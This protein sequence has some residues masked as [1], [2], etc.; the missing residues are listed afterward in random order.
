MIATVITV[1]LA[2]VSISACSS[3]SASNVTNESVAV[4][5]RD[6]NLISDPA[7]RGTSWRLWIPGDGATSV[8]GDP[9]PNVLRVSI[10]RP[11][12]VLQL[13]Q[14]TDFLPSTNAGARYLFRIRAR[15]LHLSPGIIAEIRFNYAGGGNAGFYGTEVSAKGRGRSELTAS[16]GWVTMQVA[17]TAQLPLRSIQVLVLNSRRAPLFGTV[18]LSDPELRLIKG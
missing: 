13:E 3:R 6:G 14:F 12:G 16:T 7:F 17:A 15:A 4:A 18:L 10:P 2:G 11:G 1:V 9:A 8:V 5:P